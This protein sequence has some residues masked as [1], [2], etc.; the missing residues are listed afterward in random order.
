MPSKACIADQI[1]RFVSQRYPSAPAGDEARALAL[2]WLDDLADL[3][4]AAFV[5]ACRAYRNSPVAEDRWWPTPGR[6]RA[7]L[8]A[9]RAANFLGSDADAETAFADFVRRMPA[10]SFRPDRD[11]PTG[12]AHLDPA[13]PYRNDAMFAGLAAVGGARAW[14]ASEIGNPATLGGLRKVW[15]AAYRDVRRGQVRDPE[16]LRVTAGGQKQ[17]GG[18]VA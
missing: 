4:D 9:G 16:A 6:I 2:S 15:T 5:E 7:N 10:L 12:K 8:P 18:P 14:G 1:A 13:D 11:D 17:I 3:D